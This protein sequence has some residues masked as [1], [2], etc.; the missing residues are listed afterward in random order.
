M[1]VGIILIVVGV[2]VGGIMV[3][4]PRGIWWATQSWKFRH[5]EANEPSD[6]SY[7][8]TRASGVLLICLA[9]VMGGVVISDSLSTSAAEKREQEAE[10]QQKAAEAAFVVPAPEKRGLLPAWVP[11]R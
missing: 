4:A 10:A 1:G 11:R 7:G 3:A 2:L 6:L 5:P 9:L 8:M